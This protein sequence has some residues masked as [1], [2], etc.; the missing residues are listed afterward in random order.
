MAKPGVQRE[1]TD[2]WHLEK[3]SGSA[4]TFDPFCLICLT[5]FIF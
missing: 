4:V 1:E 5:S 3:D 2:R